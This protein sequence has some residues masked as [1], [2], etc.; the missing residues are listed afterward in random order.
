MYI[1]FIF[2]DFLLNSIKLKRLLLQH[3][4]TL[5][6]F[7]NITIINTTRIHFRIHLTTTARYNP[8]NLIGGFLFR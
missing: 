4:L 6:Y 1:S 2:Q 5:T 3:L 7:T 8:P